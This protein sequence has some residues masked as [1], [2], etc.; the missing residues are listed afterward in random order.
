SKGCHQSLGLLK[1]KDFLG[2]VY[3]IFLGIR[4]HHK[5]PIDLIQPLIQRKSGS[6][7][8]TADGATEDL[9]TAAA[10]AKAAATESVA[11]EAVTAEH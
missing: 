1:L 11:V 4:F 3:D 2:F 10:T 9:V 8:V 5:A 7:L 6:E